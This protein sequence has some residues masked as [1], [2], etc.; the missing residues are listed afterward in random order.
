M[1]RIFLIISLQC[2]LQGFQILIEREWL[3]FGH[4]FGDRCGHS[5]EGDA[6]ER[7]PVFLQWLDCIHQ[8]LKQFP[9]AFEFNEYFL[10]FSS[11]SFII[12]ICI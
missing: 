10:V 12:V 9:T 11:C 8:L 5:A 7:S 6:N 1:I 3:D 2:I 4:K